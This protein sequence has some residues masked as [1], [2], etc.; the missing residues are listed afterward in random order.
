[1]ADHHS[2]DL[3]CG[4]LELP[5][6]RS[7]GFLQVPPTK[8]LR[9]VW[10]SGVP[11]WE[12][13]LESHPSCVP[14]CRGEC[15][16]SGEWRDPSQPLWVWSTGQ[17]EK[18]APGSR[19]P[20]WPERGGERGQ[21]ILRGGPSLLPFLQNELLNYVQAAIND[22]V[23]QC[24]SSAQAVSRGLGLFSKLYL[25]QVRT[26][27]PQAG[28]DLSQ[29]RASAPSVSVLALPSLAAWCLHV[30]GSWGLF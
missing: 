4:T 28:S 16:D 15:S 3:K 20:L 10:T 26:C 22:M 11:S 14:L 21:G 5:R 27:A 13:P 2:E 6:V 12:D 8:P 7:P 30:C 9:W 17:D 1:M 29:S 24:C 25:I 18:V 23:R 19:M